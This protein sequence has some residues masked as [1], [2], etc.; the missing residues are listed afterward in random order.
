MTIPP[1][2]SVETFT[3]DDFGPQTW[4]LRRLPALTNDRV[5]RWSVGL[6]IAEGLCALG[7]MLR[8]PA[9][10][11]VTLAVLGV[12]LLAAA[13]GIVLLLTFAGDAL[14]EEYARLVNVRERLHPI[15]MAAL[16]YLVLSHATAFATGYAAL[17][18]LDLHTWV[19]GVRHSYL[20]LWF[21]SYLTTF[22]IAFGDLQPGSAAV[23]ILLTLQVAASA[24]M[25]FGMVAVI[26]SSYV[27]VL[28][29]R[30]ELLIRLRSR[31]ESHDPR[32]TRRR[33]SAR[34]RER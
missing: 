23:K 22:T 13:H 12:V 16:V 29:E 5:F 14:P 18:R 24:T 32:R 20:A 1:P 15:T 31:T 33:R 6:L 19:D 17:Q 26:V 4:L 11:S 30:R 2:P 34:R 9:V 3:R 28:T 7:G 27:G 21:F 8:L 25:L 10:I